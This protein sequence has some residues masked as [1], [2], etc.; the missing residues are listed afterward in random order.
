MT[1]NII[2]FILLVFFNFLYSNFNELTIS[3]VQKTANNDNKYII[4]RCI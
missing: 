2:D 3:D 4:P 1:D